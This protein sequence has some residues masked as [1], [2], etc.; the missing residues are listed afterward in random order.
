MRNCILYNNIKHY[1][2]TFGLSQETL[3]SL[4]G[5]SKNAI[6]SFERYEYAPS[7]YVAALLCQLFKCNFDELFYLGETL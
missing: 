3:A 7:A 2:E 1:R 5:V 4:I 6:S